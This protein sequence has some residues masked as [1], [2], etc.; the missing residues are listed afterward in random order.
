MLFQNTGLK[1]SLLRGKAERG[2]WNTENL[3]GLS[4]AQTPH[5]RAL[6][7]EW[8]QSPGGQGDQGELHESRS[9]DRKQIEG[10]GRLQFVI[11]LAFASSLS[12]TQ[13]HL[14]CIDI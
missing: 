8:Q 5:Y 14:L 3:W 4:L 12:A 10:K 11:F 9:T 2:F 1:F 13:N 6:E 7:A